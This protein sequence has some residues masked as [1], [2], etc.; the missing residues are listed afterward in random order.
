MSDGRISPTLLDSAATWLDAMNPDLQWDNYRCQENGG[1][2]SCSLSMVQDIQLHS[3]W[4]LVSG[5]VGPD[6]PALES[7]FSDISDDILLVK[8]GAGNVYL[9]GDDI[10]TIG[11]WYPLEGYLVYST[12][13]HTLTLEGT[14]HA[15]EEHPLSLEPGW[16]IVSYLPQESLPVDEALS[17]IAEYIELVKD[18]SGNSYIPAVWD[19]RNWRDDTR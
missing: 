8:D 1:A 2:L 19:Q 6:D 17:S 11:S 12:S 7:I 3:G 5:N 14:I 18:E 4:N 13:D 9:P 10:N 15:P 16:N